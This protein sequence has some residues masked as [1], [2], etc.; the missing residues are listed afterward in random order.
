MK[1]LSCTFFSLLL[2][3]VAIAQTSQVWRPDLGNGKYKNPVLFADYSDPDVCRVGS[4]FYMTSSSFNAVPGLQILHSQDLVNWELVGAAL[5]EKLPGTEGLEAPQ[6]GKCVWAPSI[7]YHQGYFYIFYGDPDRGIYRLRTRDVRGIWE[8]PVLVKAGTGM[9]DPCPLWDED[10]RVYLVHALAGSRAQLKSVLCLM[11]L[12]STASKVLTDSRIIYDGH[13]QNITIE[14]PKLYKRNGFYY[15]FAP[16]GGVKTGWQIALRSTSLY[17]PY[18]EK[19]VLEQ[20]ET[21]INGP[22][23][24]AWV[25]TEMGEDWFLHFQDRGIYGR[26]VHLQ[27]MVW[28]SDWPVIGRMGRPVKGG[29]KPKTAQRVFPYQ[30]AE[31]DEFESNTLG[32]QW[33]WAA[34][35]N[36][37]WYFCDARDQL[38]RLYSYYSTESK[39]PNLLL[40]K[41]PAQAFTATAKVRFCPST[42][43][44]GERAGMIISGTQ[45]NYFVMKN[46]ADG[47]VLSFQCEAKGNN[48]AIISVKPKQWI[49]LQVQIDNQGLCTFFYSLDGEKFKK[50]AWTVPVE[51][52]EWTGAKMGLFC[53]RANSG[54][55]DG[56]WLD[57]DWFRITPYIS[58]K[59]NTKQ[60]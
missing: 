56:G 55:N 48:V 45:S 51:K 46:L 28:E 29:D 59:T 12:D 35:V 18:E 31:S 15:I 47:I 8:A 57:V 27:P 40:Q 21:E 6:Y 44:L 2:A 60:L 7:R 16:A 24:G 17:G 10:G 58:L 43:H 4:D 14:G 26:V 41:F 50:A 22:H 3:V 25:N 9:I 11:E 38:L 53:T 23:Q 52:G 13:D 19:I 33:Q 5:P 37:K 54:E 36:P 1:K 42:K 39:T 32:L 30:P 20:G 49:W 34:N